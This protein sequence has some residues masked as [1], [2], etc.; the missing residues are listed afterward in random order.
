MLGADQQSIKKFE[1]NMNAINAAQRT[2]ADSFGEARQKLENEFLRGASQGGT[3]PQR[4]QALA[5]AVADNLPAQIGDDVRERIRSAINNA[6]LDDDQQRKLIAG[7]VS[8]LDDV[9]KELGETTLSQVIEPFK[10]LN[11]VLNERIAAN[12][13]LLKLERQLV[14]AKL[15]AIDVEIEAAELVAKYSD[16]SPFTEV[17][18]RLLKRAIS[19]PRG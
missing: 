13:K 5:N 8:V 1:E 18:R 7:D 2:F 19:Q 17:N 14:D 4:Q 10:Q 11:N 9:L 16:N 6:E 3:V 12:D 15:K